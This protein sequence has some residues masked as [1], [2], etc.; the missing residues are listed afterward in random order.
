MH[1]LQ[2]APWKDYLCF[3][4]SSVRRL[5]VVLKNAISQCSGLPLGPV[6]FADGATVTNDFA[7]SALSSPISALSAQ[8]PF[9]SGASSLG[10]YDENRLDWKQR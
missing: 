1:F 4:R 3:L 6:A 5:P 9:H 8:C 2:L 10:L 7:C